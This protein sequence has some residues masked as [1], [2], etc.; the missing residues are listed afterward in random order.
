M[1]VIAPNRPYLRRLPWLCLTWLC[2][3]LGAIG[4]LL[5][6][7]PTTPFLL[8]AAW[9]A[10][11]GSPRLNRWLRHHPRLGPLIDDWHHRRAIP[12]RAKALATTM[13]LA[14]WLVLLLLKTA[15]PVLVGMALLF[16]GV[17]TYILTRPH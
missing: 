11:K 13:L 6:L 4:V 14:S 10:P 9:A 3:A 5:P 15:M 12:K 2:V 7:L 1:T 17:A 8:L 16:L